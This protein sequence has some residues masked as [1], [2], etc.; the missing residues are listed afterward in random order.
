M[1]DKYLMVSWALKFSCGSQFYHEDT[2]LPRRLSCTCCMR[3][4]ESVILIFSLFHFMWLFDHFKLRN[5]WRVHLWGERGFPGNF[6]C[7][8]RS[9]PQTAK[10]KLLSLFLIFV[11]STFFQMAKLLFFFWKKNGSSSSFSWKNHLGM[12]LVNMLKIPKPFQVILD[13]WETPVRLHQGQLFN[14]WAFLERP[15]LRYRLHC[16]RPSICFP[17]CWEKLKKDGQVH[18]HAKLKCAINL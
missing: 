13:F 17:G 1:I 3:I 10:L 8:A 12:C 2:Q 6:S 11:I 7:F 15:V 9:H 14:N 4:G 5:H 18:E 16:A